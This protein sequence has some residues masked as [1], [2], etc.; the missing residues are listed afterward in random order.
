MRSWTGAIFVCQLYGE[1]REGIYWQ[2]LKVHEI[3]RDVQELHLGLG[4]VSTNIFTVDSRLNLIADCRQS[5]APNLLNVSILTGRCF[6]CIWCRT[7]PPLVFFS[8]LS[9]VK[10]AC[11]QSGKSALSTVALS[12][13]ALPWPVLSIADRLSPWTKHGLSLSFFTLVSIVKYRL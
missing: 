1:K 13:P 12:I 9:T 7:R 5:T 11:R 3:E 10:H 4:L 8:S 6:E 2:W